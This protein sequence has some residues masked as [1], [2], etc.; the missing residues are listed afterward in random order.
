MCKEVRVESEYFNAEFRIIEKRPAK[1]TCET[2]DLIIITWNYYLIVEKLE[3]KCGDWPN[4]RHKRKAHYRWLRITNPLNP[5]K[6]KMW[7]QTYSRVVERILSFL[8]VGM[9][10]LRARC[11]WTADVVVSLMKSV[12]EPKNPNWYHPM[13]RKCWNKANFRVRTTIFSEPPDIRGSA[14]P[15]CASGILSLNIGLLTNLISAAFNVC[16]HRS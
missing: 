3:N 4:S 9:Q 2:S 1:L 6:I 11:K 7:D 5:R 14:V 10:S 13:N 15:C 12:M 8:K 16:L